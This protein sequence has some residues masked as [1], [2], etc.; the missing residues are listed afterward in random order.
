M[1]L[2]SVCGVRNW[3]L[4]ALVLFVKKTAKS[5]A[6]RVDE[7]RRGRRTEKRSNS[8]E[9]CVRVRTVVN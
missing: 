9:K 7:G 5:S 6:V 1:K 3:S 8:F 4:M 2:S